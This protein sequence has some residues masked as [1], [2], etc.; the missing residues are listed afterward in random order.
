MQSYEEWR[1]GMLQKGVAPGSY[2]WVKAQSDFMQQ[3]PEANSNVQQPES[4]MPGQ[5][6]EDLAE[7][8][9]ASNEWPGIAYYQKGPNSIK[10][11]DDPSWENRKPR[12]MWGHAKAPGAIQTVEPPEIDKP[13]SWGEDLAFPMQKTQSYHEF[14][15][16][17][18]G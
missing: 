17:F 5:W 11:G 18:Q 6:G 1:D 8:P 13:G 14:C 12:Q 10:A 2:E 15:K 16:A 7:P 4:N 3:N 9:K